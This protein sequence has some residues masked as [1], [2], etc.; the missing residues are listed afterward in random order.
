[1][2]S[3]IKEYESKESKNIWYQELDII[4]SSNFIQPHDLRFCAIC[5][6]NDAEWCE[7]RVRFVVNWRTVC[8][9]FDHWIKLLSSSLGRLSPLKNI[10]RII[11]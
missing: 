3:Q 10:S 2:L 6:D 5:G 4:L 7:K 8:R 1:M 11:F 9:D